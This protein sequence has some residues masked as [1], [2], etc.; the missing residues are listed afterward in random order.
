MASN[1]AAGIVL[2]TSFLVAYH[3]QGDAHHA[4]A[5]SVMEEV[6]SGKWGVALLPEYVFLELTTVLARRRDLAAAVS[7][8]EWLLAMEELEFVPCSMVFLDAFDCFRGF[9]GSNPSFTDAAIVAIARARRIGAVATF[10]QD[11]LR[12]E[13]IMVVPDPA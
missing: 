9:P 7:A 2:D 11:F 4:R 10:D 13:G 6:T 12:V 8:G 5:L 3:N 1:E